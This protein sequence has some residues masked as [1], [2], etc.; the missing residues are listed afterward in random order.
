MAK[1]ANYQISSSVNEGILEIALKGDV[2]NGDME[3]VINKIFTLRTSINTNNELIDVRNLNG[4]FGII[5]TYA[6]IGKLHSN[7]PRVNIAFVDVDENA[8]YNKYHEAT[9][10]KSG[11]SFK[12]FTDIDAARDWIK[13]K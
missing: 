10:M 3:T 13:S 5:E 7:R 8:V 6:F 12:W 4:R 9:A 1:K 2:N 11:I